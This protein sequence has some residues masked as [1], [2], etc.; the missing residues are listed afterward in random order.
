M[1]PVVTKAKRRQTLQRQINRLDRRVQH[2]RQQSNRFAWL[3]AAIFFGGLALTGL[4]AYLSSL[5]WLTWLTLLI[6]LVGFGVAVAIHSRLDESLARHE[7]LRQLKQ[8]HLARMALDWSHIPGITRP[9]PRYDHPFEADLDL[10]GPHSLH[11]L[12]DTAVS[13]EG[14]RRLREW[15]T[16]PRPDLR[17]TQQRQSLVRELAPRFHLRDRLIVSATVATGSRKV[18]N[19]HQLT[20]WLSHP[21]EYRAVRRWLLF[22]GPF[23]LVN[24]TLLALERLGLLPPL[25]QATFLIYFILLYARSG[26]A[27]GTFHDAMTLRDTLQQLGAVSRQLERFSYD[28]VPYLKSLCASFLIK[29]ER[30]SHHLSRINRIIIGAGL[31]QNPF[32]WL[33]LNA[34]FPWDFFFA[35]QLN[36]SRTALS[37]RV[38]DW[39]ERWADL[40]ALS[41]LANLAYLN[42]AYAWPTLFEVSQTST[43]SLFQA[44][45]LGHPLLPDATRICNDFTLAQM[46]D[47]AL[48]TGSNMAGKSTFLRT[49]GLNLALAYA[50]GPVNATELQTGLFRLFTAIKV[51]DSVTDGVSYFYAEVKRLKRLLTELE[52]EQLLPL[53]FFID[54]IFR[55][56]NNRERFIGSQAYIRAVVGQRGLGLLSTHDL[57]LTKLAEAMPTI[58]NYHF[59]DDVAGDEMIFDYK[60]HPGPCPT[61]NALKLMA[62]EGLPV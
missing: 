46:G 38:P 30:P 8:Q 21:T 47:I 23:V 1:K 15:L 11:Q 19:A 48:I 50:G 54:E 7:G 24:L 29:T 9:T 42:P 60:L 32:M 49:V 51:S 58:K 10:V 5:G 25:W 20:A 61:T 56:T 33:L 35:D 18:W 12:L 37:Q 40:E 36:R 28:R 39:L 57:E 6:I 22:F 27:E 52:A 31:R 44:T 45:D 4:I 41:S 43:Q 2:L 55:G 53:F 13:L 17:T 59:R 62:L 16:N 3:R 14:S 34:I 26:L